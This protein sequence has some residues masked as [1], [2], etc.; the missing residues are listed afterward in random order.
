ML[1]KEQINV[2][3]WSLNQWETDFKLM[4]TGTWTSVL[5]SITS[6]LSWKK[7]FAPL[8]HLIH[9]RGKE[10]VPCSAFHL[11]IFICNGQKD[12]EMQIKLPESG[13][14][15]TQPLYLSGLVSSAHWA[16]RSQGKNY[17]YCCYAA[18]HRQPTATPETSFR[19]IFQIL[20]LF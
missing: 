10:A 5:F 9:K 1:S 6:L 20:L 2:R 4:L 3:R 19:V 7:H 17:C 8:P 11:V 12:I 14:E 15:Q 18:H 13:L 16:L